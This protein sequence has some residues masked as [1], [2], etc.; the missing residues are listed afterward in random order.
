MEYQR[1]SAED[2][3]TRGSTA[4]S[5]GC[6]RQLRESLG[7]IMR[8]RVPSAAVKLVALACPCPTLAYMFTGD[9][10]P[11]QGIIKVPAWTIWN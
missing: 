1:I 7:L 6:R 5:L 4:A 9:V 10:L 3:S 8:W 11:L 2:E